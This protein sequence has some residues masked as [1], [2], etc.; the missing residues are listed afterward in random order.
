[1][2]ERN[3]DDASHLYGSRAGEGRAN[4]ACETAQLW[5]NP[6]MFHELSAFSWLVLSFFDT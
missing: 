2:T 4:W 1:M 3:P 6:P 5:L